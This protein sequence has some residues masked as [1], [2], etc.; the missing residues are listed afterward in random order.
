M[1]VESENYGEMKTIR[2]IIE[3]I[4]VILAF[5]GILARFTGLIGSVVGLLEFGIV[6]FLA[7]RLVKLETVEITEEVG[8]GDDVE[9]TVNYVDD[10]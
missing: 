4:G 2:D 1:V 7:A 10:E 3:S 5:V 8:V 9:V 6:L